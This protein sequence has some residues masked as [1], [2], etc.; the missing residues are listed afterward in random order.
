MPSRT[1]EMGNNVMKM[2][3]MSRGATARTLRFED[4]AGRDLSGV[5]FATRRPSWTG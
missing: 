2:L 5:G 1:I 3:M 4:R